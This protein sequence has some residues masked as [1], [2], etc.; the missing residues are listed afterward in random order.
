MARTKTAI[1]NMQEDS[2]YSKTAAEILD[3]TYY[4]TY[5]LVAAAT[6]YTFFAVP[7]GQAG[8]NLADTNWELSGVLPQGQQF[9]V[10][11]IK[12]IFL[13]TAALA[14]ANIQAYYNFLFD[15]TV[16]IRITGKD[17][18]GT[19]TLAEIM[20]M[21]S[22]VQATPTVAGDNVPLNTPNFKGIFPLNVPLKVGANQ[23]LKVECTFFTP[24]AAG[25]ADCYLRMC[26]QG[27]LKRLS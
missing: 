15:T 9:T 27:K 22:M 14:D 12:P 25:L 1:Q 23:T 13:S 2:A 17:S 7:L 8:K 21:S 20:G 19:W 5:K 6:T 4:D 26:M 24:I 11:V 16:E 10:F 18:L 3:W